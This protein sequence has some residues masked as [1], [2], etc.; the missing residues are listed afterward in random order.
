MAVNGWTVVSRTDGRFRTNLVFSRP[1]PA[2][3]RRRKT[4]MVIAGTAATAG[5]AAAA[6]VVASGL[7]LVDTPLAPLSGAMAVHDGD[8]DQDGL[9][10][11]V[12]VM[13]WRTHAGAIYRTDPLDADSDGD[14]VTDGDEA[15]EMLADPFG[16]TAYAGPSD[17]T[18][19]DSDDDGLDD[20]TEHESGANAWEAD[21]D[22]D[23]V[24]DM[25]EIA[26]GSDPVQANADGDEYDDSEEIA[27][28][29]DS[30]RYDL[31]RTEGAEAFA[32]GMAGGDVGGFGVDLIT[33]NDRQQASW[34]YAVGSVAPR[35][36]KGIK[37][38]R[39][40][41]AVAQGGQ[42][43]TAADVMRLLPLLGDGVDVVGFV[44]DF[45]GEGGGATHAAARLLAAAPGLSQA[46]K[47]AATSTVVRRDPTSMRLDCDERVRGMAAPA[48]LSA[49]RPISSIETQNSR[50]DEIVEE[51]RDQ[52]FTDI[53]VNQMQVDAAGEVVGV[54][55]PDV[56]ATDPDGTRHYVELDTTADLGLVHLARLLSNDPDGEVELLQLG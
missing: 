2:S 46:S 25:A 13:G 35:V 9:I 42:V 34:Q 43:A 37:V 5:A 19:S 18:S 8:S 56:Q 28:G 38:G 40:A 22:S 27:A 51:L 36:L 24:D 50:K 23:G 47:I 30:Y 55:R 32:G 10:D 49:S 48:A 11:S 21:S 15:G 31:T 41:I 4:L 16:D 3:T 54:I 33:L 39:V 12:E 45:A 29:S 26:F 44:R 14:E 20:A 7:S 53:R 52:G 6:I 1:R 17:P